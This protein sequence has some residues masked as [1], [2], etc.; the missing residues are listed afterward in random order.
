MSCFL[1]N[2]LP[3]HKLFGQCVSACICWDEIGRWGFF[4]RKNL[5]IALNRNLYIINYKLKHKLKLDMFDAWF[6]MWGQVENANVSMVVILPSRIGEFI[7][8]L[9][10]LQSVAAWCFQNLSSKFSHKEDE[11]RRGLENYHE[12]LGC[13]WN[14]TNPIGSM[15]GIFTY[16]WLKFMVNVGKYTIHGS[17]GNKNWNIVYIN[18]SREISC[19]NCILP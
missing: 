8:Y 6:M 12:K 5:F 17:Y 19:V 4:L 9:S 2:L 15:Y 1:H 11:H 13:I 10:F 7:I 14:T 3:C 18:W 16:I